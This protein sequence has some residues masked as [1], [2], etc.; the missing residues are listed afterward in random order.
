[1]R[2]TQAVIVFEELAAIA[3]YAPPATAATAANSV[4]LVDVLRSLRTNPPRRGI[5][6]A[7]N[8]S[9]AEFLA[10]SPRPLRPG[11][12][13]L[14]TLGRRPRGRALLSKLAPADQAAAGLV[15]M[16]RYD[17]PERARALGWDAETVVA[18]GRQL[19]RTEGRP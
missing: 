19:R 15:G 9:L 12:R 14:V 6:S 7:V 3:A 18:R 10:A 2:C 5:I 4:A 8:D 17:E 16:G 13:L 11:L 1:M